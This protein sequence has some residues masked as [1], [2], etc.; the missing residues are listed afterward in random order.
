MSGDKMDRLL[1]L[2][3]DGTLFDTKDVN[4]KAYSQAIKDCGYDK[5][6]DYRY[7]C[8]FCNGNSYRVFLPG[9]V[10]GI[11]EE[12]M[13]RI[14]ERKSALYPR[15]LWAAR[16]NE[17]LFDM[18]GLLR[19]QYRTALVTAASRVNTE[20]ILDYFHEKDSFDFII[21]QEDVE[22]TKPDPEA[23]IKAMR[24]AGAD[25]EHTVICEDSESGLAAAEATGALYVRVY[26][27][28]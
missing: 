14:H 12:G 20:D 26:G 6:I 21:T 7:Y 18:V 9:I 22:R 17:L 3:L 24:L 16:K 28:N 10:P 27:Y 19:P 2:D 8:G 4:Y 11:S 1:I 15:Y 13:R 23:F 5:T 25:R